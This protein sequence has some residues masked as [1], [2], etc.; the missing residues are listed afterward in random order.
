MGCHLEVLGFLLVLVLLVLQAALVGLVHLLLLMGLVGLVHL[1][2]LVGLVHL[3]ALLVLA[4][5]VDP[6]ALLR[7]GL[8]V[9]LDHLQLLALVQLESALLDR[10]PW[11][12][13]D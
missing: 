4:V 5:L 7:V 6:L 1:L 9:A 8:E 11:C 12:K 13:K 10:K 3:L 2:V